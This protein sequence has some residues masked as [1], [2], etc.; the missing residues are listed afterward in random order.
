VSSNFPLSYQLSWL[1]RF[2]VP[3]LGGDDAGF[4]PPAGGS[5]SSAEKVVRLVFLGDISAVASR[6]APTIDKTLRDKIASAQLVLANCES[7]VVASPRKQPGTLLGTRHAMTAQ[8]LSEVVAAAGIEANRLVLSLANNHALDQGRMGFDETAR[9]LAD[10]GI[11]TVGGVIGGPVAVIDA[12]SMT[13][14]IAAFTEWR[15]APSAEFAGRV[16]TRDGFERDGWDA[17][18]RAEADL[19]C[20]MPHWDMEF[21]H[22]PQPATRSTAKRLAESGVD[23]VVGG[24]AHVVQPVERIGETLVAYGLGDFLGTAWARSRWPLRLGAMLLVDIVAPTSLPGRRRGRIA[25]YEVV[26][27]LRQRERGRERLMPLD[28][29]PGILGKDVEA[30]WRAVFHHN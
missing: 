26:P 12:G 29:V 22:F 7:P 18:E 2:L 6:K 3:S 14:G 17:L 30:R 21:R 13:I 11:R 28:A 19:L 4:A 25:S 8:F 24:H 20:A 10:L 1:P 23:L 16:M 15:N 5:P 27:F 9:E